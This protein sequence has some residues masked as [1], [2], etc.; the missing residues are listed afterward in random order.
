M[1]RLAGLAAAELQAEYWSVS[2][3]SGF[4]VTE[5]FQRIA[6]LAFEEAVMQ[7]IRSIKNKPQEQATQASVK[8]QTFGKPLFENS[9][10]ISLYLFLFRFTQ[11]LWK[12]PLA[13]E[14]WLYLLA[15]RLHNLYF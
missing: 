11:L 13:T 8:S 4:K 12:P 2:A 1:E 10:P 6:A 5:L 15:C 3:R 9:Y 14:K 7:E